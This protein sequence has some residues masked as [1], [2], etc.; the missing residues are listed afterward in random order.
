MNRSHTDQLWLPP[1]ETASRSPTI[2]S[3]GFGHFGSP[4]IR[5]AEGG[6]HEPSRPFP[7]TR[8]VTSTA[9]IGSVR[10]RW[11]PTAD[12]VLLGEH[13]FSNNVVEK[14]ITTFPKYFSTLVSN[15]LTSAWL[16]RTFVHEGATNTGPHSTPAIPMAHRP[17]AWVAARFR[18]LLSTVG[19]DIASRWSSS[20]EPSHHRT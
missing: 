19:T 16:V 18:R 1:Y 5:L 13:D 2:S 9:A 11:L 20:P 14:S 7:G 10:F 6:R 12:H 17:R 4:G 15:L 8:A 3:S